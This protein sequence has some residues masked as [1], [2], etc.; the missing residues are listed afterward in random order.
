M[1]SRGKRFLIGCGFGCGALILIVVAAA[2]I[3]YFW[4]NQ[5]TELLAPEALVGGDTTGHVEWTL[6]LED[7]GTREFVEGLLAVSQDE[8]ARDMDGLPPVVQS[9]LLKYQGSQNERKLRELFPLVAAW[10]IHPGPTP[11][12]DL[13]LISVA[14]AKLGNQLTFADWIM[15]LTLSR[16]EE[17]VVVPYQDEKIYSFPNSRGR[18]V[19]L[20]IRKKTLF[21]ATDVETAKQAVDRLNNPVETAG[22]GALPGLMQSVGADRPLRGALTNERGELRRLWRRLWNEND[23][24]TLWDNVRALKISG[25]FEESGGFGGTV[26][27]RCVDSAWA[28]AN[29][30]NLAGALTAACELAGL[31][32]ETD[33][34][35]AGEWVTIEF[36]MQNLPE[37]IKGLMR[38]GNIRI[39]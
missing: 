10:T 23:P 20:F 11:E 37:L 5:P 18:S 38:T 15:G 12:K 4:I 9:W 3:F 26:E 2:V 29:A 16:A 19:V 30:D 32:V 25:G 33:V 6:R 14:V 17:A 8:A 39:G 36:R 28:D 24:G 21:F 27:L 13:Q 35:T 1:A 22:A 31:E 7:P 34:R